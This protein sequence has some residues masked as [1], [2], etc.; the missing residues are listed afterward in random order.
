[1]KNLKTTALILASLFIILA[2]KAQAASLLAVCSDNNDVDT[3]PKSKLF[4]P[5]YAKSGSKTPFKFKVD[6]SGLGDI[7]ADTAFNS[8]I[9][10][11]DLWEAESSLE[12]QQVDGGKFD[13]DIDISNYDP[14][15]NAAHS[16]GFSPIVYDADGSITDDLLGSGSKTNVLG[17]AG[18][19]FFTTSGGTITGIKESQAVFNGYLYK[20]SNVGG[21]F[22]SV[23]N[24]FTTTILHEFGHMFGMDHTQGGDLDGF[25]AHASDLTDVPVMF[26]IAAN[27]LVELQK[28]DTASVKEAYPLGTE[29]S[30][31]GRIEGKLLKNG[32]PIKG[33]NV[34]A[35]K[36]DDSNP[37][38]KA[39]ASPSDVDGAGLGTFVMPNLDPGAYIVKAEPIDSDFVDG[40]S[41]GLHSPINSNLMTTG[42]YKG[43]GELVLATSSLN[44]GVN[45][46]LQLNVTAGSTANIVFDIG[47]N[48]TGGDS[49]NNGQGASFTLSGRAINTSRGIFLN[50]FS[51]KTLK[52]KITN[53]TPGQS[54]TVKLSTDYPD[55]IQFIPSDTIT[56]RKSVKQVTVRFAG[57]LLFV[58]AV[59]DLNDLGSAFIPL[60]VEDLGTGYIDDT[61]GFLVF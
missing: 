60:T 36:V 7:D 33:A 10:V 29:A 17:F 12:F 58:D 20:T 23:L 16:L 49:T 45:Q 28:D 51:T 46:A 41:V 8:T 48:P 25:N 38:K 57:Y 5:I 53:L 11:L 15:L 19:T 27:T 43:D 6:P 42:F 52:L 37:R 40:S 1:M 61:Q 35:F 55:L 24:D 47:S 2:I 4:F 31:Y 30:L 32:A 50:S 9:E 18:A 59:S 22:N 39:V 26:P 13:T 54:K 56:F 3:C 14:I 44:T 34:V 21:T